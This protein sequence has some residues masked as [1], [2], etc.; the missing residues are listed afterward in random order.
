MVCGSCWVS[1]VD[2]HDALEWEW[3]CGLGMVDCREIQEGMGCFE[4]HHLVYL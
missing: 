2:L 3:V 1:Q 4:P